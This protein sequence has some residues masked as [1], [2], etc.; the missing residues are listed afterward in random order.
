[1]DA[2][3]EIAVT[4]RHLYQG[5]FFA[6]LEQIVAARPAAV[7][8]REKDLDAQAYMRLATQA[9]AVCAAQGVPLIAHSFAEAARAAGVARLHLPFAALAAQAEA[10]RDFAQIGASVHSAAEAAQARALG[11]A[12]VIFGN[13]FATSCKP[14][15][16]GRGLP[17]L[18]EACAAAALP[19]YAIGGVT[20]KNAPDCIQAGAA[21]IC[22]MGYWGA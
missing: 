21:G 18:A 22:R 11:A 13:V 5:D 16:P 20:K 9:Q 12:Y 10:L 6:R 15:L 8:L 4:N 3:P 2:I 19:V 1:M 7:L 14:G 17:A